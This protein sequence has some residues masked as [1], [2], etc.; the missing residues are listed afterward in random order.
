MYLGLRA[1][2]GRISAA[3]LVFACLLAFAR[4]ASAQAGVRVFVPNTGADTVTAFVTDA[5]GGLTLAGTIPL[6]AGSAPV[7][8]TMSTDQR[9]AYVSNSGT[10]DVTVID[11]AALTVAQTM[12]AGVV[13]PRFSA[14]RPDGGRLYV[15]NNSG[16]PGGNS[17]GL[18]TDNSS[19]L[20]WAR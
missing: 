16:A 3:L 10:N 11:A 1:L 5:I 9:F 14:I 17:V 19:E 13:V 4:G 12:P 7:G 18:L 2:R 20:F 15:A 8:V 6:A